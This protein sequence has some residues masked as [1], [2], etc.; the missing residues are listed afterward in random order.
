MRFSAHAF[1]DFFWNEVHY[2]KIL[3]AVMNRENMG[4]IPNSSPDM[5]EWIVENWAPGE[6]KPDRYC[7]FM[8]HLEELTSEKEL[9]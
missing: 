7:D 2:E 8:H 6:F 3:Q 5:S 1:D 9:E 4:T